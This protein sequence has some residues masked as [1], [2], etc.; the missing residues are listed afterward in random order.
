MPSLAPCAGFN[1]KCSCMTWSPKEG[2]IPRGYGGGAARPSEIELALVLGEPGPPGTT[3]T[4]SKGDKAMDEITA[5]V[6]NNVCSSNSLFHRNVRRILVLCYPGETTKLALTRAWLT[7]SLQC[8]TE[9]AL[10]DAP[11]DVRRNCGERYLLPQYELLNHA[12]RLALGGKADR[13]MRHLGI[14]QN[15]NVSFLESILGLTHAKALLGHLTAPS[16][17]VGWWSV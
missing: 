7:E 8:S 10:G 17:T 3:E 9:T 5:N 16:I 1:G 4:Y 12:F 13:R 14:I 2:H 15:A 11:K 6:E